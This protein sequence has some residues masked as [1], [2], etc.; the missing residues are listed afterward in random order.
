MKK[1][2]KTRSH[3][4]HKSL[5]ELNLEAIED[6]I[7]SLG[8]DEGREVLGET[9][10]TLGRSKVVEAIVTMDLTKF[11]QWKQEQGGGPQLS[12]PE[13]LQQMHALTM[14]AMGFL[15]GGAKLVIQDR[16][17]AGETVEAIFNK[18]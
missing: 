14:F 8:S 15:V 7:G 2:R 3:V 11:D 17:E 16:I 9:V 6:L 5:D 18:S 10:L 12:S 13:Q 4:H 1:Q